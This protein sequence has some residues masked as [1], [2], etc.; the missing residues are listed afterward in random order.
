LKNINHK[1][2][3]EDLL[4][5][6]V[7]DRMW[8]GDRTLAEV[9][10]VSLKGGATFLQLR[11]KALSHEEFVKEAL[12]LKAVAKKY[13]VPF[14]INDNIQVAKEID[15]DGIHIGQDDITLEEARRIL[16]AD[17]IIGVSAK[18]VE[19]SM[20]AQEEGAD[21]LGIGAMFSTTTKL[22]AYDITKE[23]LTD[24]CRA[25]T[26]PVV[27]IGGIHIGNVEKLQETGIAGVAVVSALYASGDIER[28]AQ[29]LYQKLESV[30][31][32][33]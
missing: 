25:V 33:K 6:A 20:K 13:G 3:A 9:V 7:T 21:Y 32:R 5:Y 29:T 28:A 23:T 16:G 1:T 15:A 26:I 11:E 4:L 17:K 31:K 24:I 22:D 18:T 2:L 19:Q 12:E 27:A 10:E 14:V 8:L 30:I